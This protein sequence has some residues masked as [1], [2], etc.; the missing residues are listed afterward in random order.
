MRTMRKQGKGSVGT[1]SWDDYNFFPWHIP[2]ELGKHGLKGRKTVD[3]KNMFFMFTHALY[4]I[5][6]YL[7]SLMRMKG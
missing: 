4:Y 6:L 2:L 5:L 1:E 7:I 3:L